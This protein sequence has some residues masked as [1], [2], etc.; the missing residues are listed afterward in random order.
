MN[1]LGLPGIARGQRDTLVLDAFSL[2]SRQHLDGH[3][4]LVQEQPLSPYAVPPAE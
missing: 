2:A 4:I 1:D 3:T